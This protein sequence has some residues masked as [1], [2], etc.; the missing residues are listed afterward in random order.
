MGSKSVPVAVKQR[1]MSMHMDEGDT[2][3]LVSKGGPEAQ[4]TRLVKVPLWDET[5]HRTAVARQGWG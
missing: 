3:A 4:L 5:V 2:I 1:D